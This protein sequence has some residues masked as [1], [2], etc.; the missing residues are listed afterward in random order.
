MNEELRTITVLDFEKS[1]VFQYD[2][3][4]FG[5][6]YIFI[7][8]DSPNNDEL[9]DILGNMSAEQYTSMLPAIED[10]FN[11]VQEFRLS[12]DWIFK[13]YPFLFD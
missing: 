11:R 10:N 1:K 8:K 3:D 2:L 5:D 7:D 6:N 4:K 12:E 13:T 9:E